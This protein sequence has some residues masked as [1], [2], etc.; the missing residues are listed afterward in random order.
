MK[1]RIVLAAI[2]VFNRLT[3]GQLRGRPFIKGESVDSRFFKRRIFGKDRH[4]APARF[5]SWASGV[6]LE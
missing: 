2:L 3:D 5:N 4:L 1:G 6:P